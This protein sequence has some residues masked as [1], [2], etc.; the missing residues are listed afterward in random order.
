MSRRALCESLPFD[1]KLLA[2]GFVQDISLTIK[3]LVKHSLQVFAQCWPAISACSAMEEL[4]FQIV[5]VL[6]MPTT[7]PIQCWSLI[8]L[9]AFSKKVRPYGHAMGVVIH[10]DF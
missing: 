10:A 2:V 7:C 3:F 4:G 1:V 5:K 6:D 9:L 8:Q